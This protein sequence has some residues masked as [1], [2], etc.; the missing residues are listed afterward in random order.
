MKKFTIII[1]SNCDLPDEYIAQHDIKTIPMPFDLDGVTHDQGR[2]Q[3]ITAGDFYDTL[4][5]G[6]VAKTTLINPE[7]FLTEY[8]KYAE[9]SEDAMV[10]A[11]SRGLSSTYQNS[12]IALD[13]IKQSYPDCGIFSI[14]T[15]SA[16]SGIGL[17]VMMAVK[18]RSEGL[19]QIGRDF[20]MFSGKTATYTVFNGCLQPDNFS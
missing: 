2:W 18:K 7:T 19:T 20:G 4:R 11:I 15:V 14:D 17:L 9:K 16:S 3:E 13:E 10:F 1:E 6:G 8:T 5:R 12:L